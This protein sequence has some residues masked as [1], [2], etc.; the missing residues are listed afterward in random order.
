[1]IKD[2]LDKLKERGITLASAE[3]LTGGLFATTVT[4]YPGASSYFK[5]AAV[6]YANEAKETIINVPKKILETYG[7]I[8]KETAEAMA[9][10][11]KKLFLV[12]L[13]VSFT[14]NAGPD[15][16]EGKPKGLVY[17][18]ICY[19]STSITIENLFEGNREEI[20]QKCIQKAFEKIEELIEG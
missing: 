13:A 12:D 6:T 1:M 17:I 19:N 16:L 18:G 2:V 15:V 11:V 7:A 9:R 4:S 10:G 5:G 14:G 3:S 8:S 20:R